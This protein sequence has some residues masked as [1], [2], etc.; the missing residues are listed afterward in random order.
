M[1]AGDDCFVVPD[2][3]RI[4]LTGGR[5]IAVKRRLNYGEVR[6]MRTR[7]YTV[8]ADGSLRMNLLQVGFARVTAYLLDWSLTDAAGQAVPI[9]RRSLEELE[10]KLDALDPAVYTEI[11]A[12]I[13]RHDEALGDARLREKKPPTA[14]PGD[15]TISPSPSAAAGALTGF[16][17]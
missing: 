13:L 9:R 2:E 6:Q 14:T 12:A 4:D 1:M 17:N 3:V 11:E 5:W 16:V 8:E 7:L 15:A 10:A